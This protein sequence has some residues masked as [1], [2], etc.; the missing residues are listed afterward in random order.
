VHTTQCRREQQ[1][2]ITSRQRF[3]AHGDQQVGGLCLVFRNDGCQ[4]T[5]TVPLLSIFQGVKPLVVREWSGYHQR[6]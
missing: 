6:A 1:Q 5:K 2:Q 4:K 3:S